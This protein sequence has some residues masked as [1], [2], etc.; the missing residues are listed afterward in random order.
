M[1]SLPIS[2]VITSE[3]L[4]Q[5]DKRTK[6]FALFKSLQT[7]IIQ[8]SESSCLLVFVYLSAARAIHR[9]AKTIRILLVQLCC[10]FGAAMLHCWYTYAGPLV[11]LCWTFGTKMLYS[12]GTVFSICL[13]TISRR[14]SEW[15]MKKRSSAAGGKANEELSAVGRLRNKVR[16]PNF[17]S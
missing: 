9:L 15:R 7:S 16:R 5:S 8:V 17:V 14:E 12:S 6:R 4:L 3:A 1:N 11:Y 13:L 10:T 2:T